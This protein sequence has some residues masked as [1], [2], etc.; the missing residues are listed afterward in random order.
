MKPKALNTV[1]LCLLTSL[2]ASASL[3]S[4]AAA[5]PA[6]KF[7]GAEL[8]GT[9]ILIGGTTESTLTIPGLTTKCNLVYQMKIK[10]TGGT[11]EGE[12]TYFPN[13]KCSTNSKACTVETIEA[14][15][16]PWSAQLKT[17]G[18]SKYLVI[19]PLEVDIVYSGELCVLEGTLVKVKGSAG[20]RFDQGSQSFVFNSTTFSATGTELKALGQKIE[21]KATLSTEAFGPHLGET[22]SIG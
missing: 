7:E 21:W 2:L 8:T 17:V 9:E 4:S 20:G 11:G 15:A 14:Q 13:F 6:W 22:L 5:S 3:A 1:L 10:N 19:N 16:L 12:V 18:L